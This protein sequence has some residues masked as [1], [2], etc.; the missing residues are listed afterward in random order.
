MVWG[1]VLDIQGAEFL[2]R[3]YGHVSVTCMEGASSVRA[4]YQSDGKL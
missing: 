3:P 4:L 1:D 2:A